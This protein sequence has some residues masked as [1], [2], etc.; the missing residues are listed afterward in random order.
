MDLGLLVAASDLGVATTGVL[1]LL[2]RHLLVVDRQLDVAVT[3]LGQ[4]HSGSGEDKSGGEELHFDGCFLRKAKKESKRQR[5]NE[6]CLELK[7]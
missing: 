5:R 2:Q 3:R 4:G 1:G 7:S 6:S